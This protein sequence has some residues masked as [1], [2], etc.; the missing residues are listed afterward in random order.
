M[1]PEQHPYG[2]LQEPNPAKKPRRVPRVAVAAGVT[3]FLGLAGAGLA[4]ATSGGGTPAASLSS[5]SSSSTTPTTVAKSPHPRAGK[6]GGP[7]ML[8]PG[9]G[10][11]KVVH[12]QYTIDVGGTYKTIA[13]QTGTVAAVSSTSITVTSSDGVSQTFVVDPSTVV[14]SQAN[15]IGSV[16]KG[17]TV[18]VE[19]LVQGGTMTATNIVDSTKVGSSRKGF[20]LVPPGGQGANGAARFGPPGP[21]TAQA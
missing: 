2:P 15:G 4:F 17:D 21:P 20:G 14:D 3:V 5:S 7:A 9:M 19:A 11:G 8:G 6:F 12:G 16:Q 10:L 18:N 13:V 1:Q